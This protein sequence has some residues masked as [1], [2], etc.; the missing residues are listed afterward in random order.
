M[1][2][3]EMCLPR[4]VITSQGTHF[5]NACVRNVILRISTYLKQKSNC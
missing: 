5:Y 4:F 1:R 3:V 2:H